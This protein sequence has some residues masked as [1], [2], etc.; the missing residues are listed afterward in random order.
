MIRRGPRY[1]RTKMSEPKLKS[2]PFCDANVECVVKGVN[3]KI[4]VELKRIRK[5]WEWKEY[6]HNMNNRSKYDSWCY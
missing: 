2:C 3:E 1:P 4:L 5:E 6:L